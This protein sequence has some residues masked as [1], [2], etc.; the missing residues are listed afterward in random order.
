MNFLRTRT[1]TSWTGENFADRNRVRLQHQQEELSAWARKVLGLV[2]QE[3]M[4]AGRRVETIEDLDG[5]LSEML[6]V[7]R[8][9]VTMCDRAFLTIDTS[10]ID[11]HLLLPTRAPGGRHEMTAALVY[12]QHLHRHPM[13]HE[14][15]IHCPRTP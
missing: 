14:C 2:H 10:T 9:V 15:L 3:H 1:L 13:G 4:V 11:D 12:R 5:R 6:L 8:A 7:H